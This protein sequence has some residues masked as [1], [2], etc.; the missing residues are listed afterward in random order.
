M[1]LLFGMKKRV[2]KAEYVT[3]MSAI[4]VLSV[5]LISLLNVYEQEVLLSPGDAIT[6][7]YIFWIIVGVVALLVLVGVVFCH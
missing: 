1:F 7:N 2:S 4:V 6:D 5:L 3:W